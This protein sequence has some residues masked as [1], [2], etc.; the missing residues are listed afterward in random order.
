MTNLGKLPSTH[1]ILRYVVTRALAVIVSASILSAC[2]GASSSVPTYGSVR[3]IDGVGIQDTSSGRTINFDIRGT[4]GSVHVTAITSVAYRSSGDDITTHFQAGK[5]NWSIEY[6][7][8]RTLNKT[9]VTMTNI[10]GR[11]KVFTEPGIVGL[12]S[13]QAT[14]TAI[15]QYRNRVQALRRSPQFSA[16][17]GECGAFCIETILVGPEVWGACYLTC[18]IASGEFPL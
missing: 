14:A 9:V 12:E 6:V 4:H 2:S 15:S 13:D 7:Q 11:Q 3:V 5:I 18:L 8:N 16:I 1:M 17:A 10:Q